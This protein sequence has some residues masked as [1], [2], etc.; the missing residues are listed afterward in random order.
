MSDSTVEKLSSQIILCSILQNLS[1][2]QLL[3]N[4]FIV[5]IKGVEHFFK[6]IQPLLWAGSPEAN[7]DFI[8]GLEL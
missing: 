7:I 8:R 1:F 4:Y 5:W 6:K 3:L 2:S